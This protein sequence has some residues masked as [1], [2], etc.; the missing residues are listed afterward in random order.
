MSACNFLM[1]YSDFLI[2]IVMILLVISIIYGIIYRY[3]NLAYTVPSYTCFILNGLILL[4]YFWIFYL[5]IFK[6]EN[7][8]YLEDISV[9]SQYRYL[10]FVIC[11]FIILCF[12]LLIKFNETLNTFF[13]RFLSYIPSPS[14]E[15]RL[16]LYSYNNSWLGTLCTK[17]ID[18][19]FSNKKFKYLFFLFHFLLYYFFK[20][21]RL[22]LFISFTFFHMDLRYLIY[23]A[24]LSFIIWILR[25][26]FFYFFWFANSNE[27]YM[28]QVLS[29]KIDPSVKQRQH[30]FIITSHNDITLSITNFGQ[31]EGFSAQ[32]LTYLRNK[33][34]ILSY[35]VS[36]IDKY[37][38]KVFYL[39]YIGLIIFFICWVKI[40]HFF[41]HDDSLH[42]VIPFLRNLQKTFRGFHSTPPRFANDSRFVKKQYEKELEERSSAYKAGHPVIGEQIG[43]KYK[44][45]VQGTSGRGTHE[46]PS[47]LIHKEK[48]LTGENGR[49]YGIAIPEGG[50]ELDAYKLHSPIPGSEGY[51][52]EPQTRKNID[53]LINRKDN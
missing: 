26:F 16:I 24:P 11:S 14:E 40:S 36:L 23:L 18:L 19:M 32:D 53:D 49:Q 44:I 42:A 13:I 41:F 50:I 43:S 2:L 8:I 17:T 29:I 9:F 33:F 35:V 21:I 1:A 22:S 3:H 20:I 27:R 6:L 39:R 28:L 45:K 4:S 30:Y 46:N 51:T 7:A 25:F 47:E 12:Y 37:H 48:T 34:I 38:K 10:I 15:V 5:I 31:K 52:N